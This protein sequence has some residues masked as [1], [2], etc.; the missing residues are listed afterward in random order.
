L[1]TVVLVFLHAAAFFGRSV[2][3]YDAAFL[4]G[5][6]TS[7]KGFKGSFNPG[8]NG[9]DSPSDSINLEAI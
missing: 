2:F 9:P 8:V 1:L 7:L 6:R 3:L 4:G 5:D